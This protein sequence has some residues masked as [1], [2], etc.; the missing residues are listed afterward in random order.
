VSSPPT[1]WLFSLAQFGIKFGLDNIRALLAELGSPERQFRSLHVAGT[2]GKGSVT[3]IAEQVLRGTGLRTGRYT[4]PHLLALAERFAIDG[5]PIAEVD[6]LETVDTVREA[7]SRL[8][9]R[10]TLE[11]HPTFFEVTTAVAFELFRRHEVDIAVCEV[12]LGGR[13]DA[14]NVLDPMAC[15][16][17]SI[18]FDHEQYL[19]S[20]LRE[21]ASEKAGIIKPG[22]PVVVGPVGRDA[23]ET[24]QEIADTR[25]APIVWAAD[26]T[27]IGDPYVLPTGGQRFHL[28]TPSR[29][30]DTVQLALNGRHQIMNAVVAVRLLEQ[31]ETR[32][33][34][35]SRDAMVDGLAAVRWPGRLEH[36]P[37]PGG[38]SVLLDAAHNAAG[39]DALA[40]YLTALGPARPLVFAA[41]RD[42]DAASMLRALAPRAS[43]V[44]VTRA[45]NP[46]AA[47]P[48]DLAALARQLSSHVPVETAESPAEALAI[49][50]Q[51]APDIVVAGSIFLLA[52]AMKE[53]GRS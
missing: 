17:T 3:A 13:L 21:I 39:A 14:T 18:A 31:L 2:N 30:Y 34:A 53:L 33:I 16:I 47:D 15:A 45:S 7:V 10:G 43:R 36:V 40:E 9:A 12:G 23:H 19:G 11:V 44:I 48:A 52:D 28:A 37:V 50:W 22:V 38:R 24:I 6:L 49:A 41:M 35:I 46:R 25:H 4:S 29:N 42:K 51:Y 5:Q 8:Q 27:A 20:T 1:D 32:G 26:G